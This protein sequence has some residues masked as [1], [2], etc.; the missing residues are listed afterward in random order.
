MA[1]RPV[2]LT[3]AEGGINLQRTKGSARANTLRDFLNGYV[4][5]DGIPTPRYGSRAQAITGAG[6]LPKGLTAYKKALYAFAHEPVA[7]ATQAGQKPVTTIALPN[8]LDAG[9][10][11]RKVWFV[12]EY[13]GLL[14]VAAEYENDDVEHFWMESVSEWKPNT[15]YMLG[16]LVRQTSGG[17]VYV[18]RAGRIGDPYPA[19]A[20]GASRTLGERV[21]PTTQNGWYY[22]VT[23]ATGDTPRS[24]NVEPAWPTTVGAV[25][26]EDVDGEATG[27]GSSAPPPDTS[28][29]P[30]LGDRYDNPNTGGNT[31]GLSS[32]VQ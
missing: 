18:F 16:Q 3:T 29:P 31:S 22:E 5:H 2:N 26:Y 6:T 11:I 25:V 20:P 28:L 12:G 32:N 10:P 14:Y 1:G 13:M 8:R 23:E 9:S 21:E 4:D 27:G 19:W 24:G 7:W 15:V 17:G 30:G